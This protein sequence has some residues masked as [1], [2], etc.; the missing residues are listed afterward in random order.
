MRPV[1]LFL[2]QDAT[3]A[4]FLEHIIYTYLCGKETI[5]AITISNGLSGKYF[6]MSV[7]DMVCTDL[8]RIPVPIRREHHP[9]RP[10]QP[11]HTLC[12]PDARGGR[13]DTADRR[14]CRQQH[15]VEP[16]ADFPAG[17]LRGRHTNNLRGLDDEP[18]PLAAARN[19]AHGPRPSRPPIPTAAPER[20]LPWSSAATAATPP[21]T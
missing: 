3:S 14:I 16:G 8:L 2:C 21:S 18:L 13:E 9:C 5:M 4:V 20:S 1:P 15:S 17:L 7:P 10:W 6:S 12:P 11:A 19:E